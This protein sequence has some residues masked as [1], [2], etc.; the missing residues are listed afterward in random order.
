MSQR[1]GLGVR[2]RI[3]AVL[4]CLTALAAPS[5]SQDAKTNPQTPPAAE[6]RKAT[7]A[8]PREAQ[9]LADTEKL[10]KLS[11]ELKA[12]VDKSTKD[13]LSLAVIKKAEEVEKLA[14]SIKERLNK[15][16]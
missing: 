2:H 6:T 16:H 9:L 10:L 3:L 13:T 7:P 14:K 11:Q 5:F 4:L 8:D 15:T 12:E 1:P